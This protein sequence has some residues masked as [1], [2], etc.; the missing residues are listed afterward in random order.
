MGDVGVWLAV[1][2]LGLML[3]AALLWL[4]QGRWPPPGPR[5]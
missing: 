1:L 2:G 5:S 3:A 4:A